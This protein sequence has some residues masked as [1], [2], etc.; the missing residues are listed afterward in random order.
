MLLNF[1]SA[2]QSQIEKESNAQKMR[3]IKEKLSEISARMTGFQRDLDNSVNTLDQK[4]VDVESS[5]ADLRNLE[6]RKR[7]IEVQINSANSRQSGQGNLAKF[8]NYVPKLLEA[9]EEAYKKRQ[10]KHKPIGPCG[11]CLKL[12]IYQI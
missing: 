3:E 7:N 9:I 5:V 8:G 6:H 1:F 10:F 12:K 2:S 4:N 11:T